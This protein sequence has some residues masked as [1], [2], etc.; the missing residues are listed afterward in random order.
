MRGTIIVVCRW[1]MVYLY[2]RCNV[3]RFNLYNCGR[4]LVSRLLLICLRQLCATCLSRC[5]VMNANTDNS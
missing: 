1:S 3:P 5:I 4:L 2:S